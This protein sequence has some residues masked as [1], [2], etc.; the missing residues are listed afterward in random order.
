MRPDDDPVFRLRWPHYL[1]AGVAYL[2]LL[3]AWAPASLMTGLLARNLPGVRFEPPQ[4]SFWNGH[5]RSEIL[6]AAQP[7]GVGLAWRFRPAELLSGGLGYAVR[8]EAEQ[9]GAEGIVRLGP[10][11]LDL[12]RVEA[13]AALPWLLR[14]SPD[15]ASLPFDG[16]LQLAADRL[17]LAR[18]AM[19]GSARVDWLDAGFSGHPLGRYRLDA[20]SGEGALALRLRTLAGPL[21]LAGTGTWRSTGEVRF[22]GTAR[23]LS[24]TRDLD[25]VLNWLGPEHNGTHA[26]RF[27]R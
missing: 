4:G 12:R 24:A 13:H 3:L 1:L 20:E 14:F 25:G 11:R 8:L 16:R 15:L 21:E 9:A 27:P 26:F 5:A 19:E 2:V 22:S 23:A 17:V 7:L 10:G 6:G 18:K